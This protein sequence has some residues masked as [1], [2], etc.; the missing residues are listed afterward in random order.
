MA[1]IEE[2]RG[3]I[4]DRRVDSKT[5]EVVELV[6]IELRRQGVIEQE[7]A[8]FLA[9]RRSRAARGPVPNDRRRQRRANPTT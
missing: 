5:R 1:D 4:T 7:I 2:K 3:A 6:I 9:R 8:A